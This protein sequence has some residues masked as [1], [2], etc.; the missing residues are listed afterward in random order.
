[1]SESDLS[2]SSTQKHWRD[3]LPSTVP[4][5]CIYLFFKPCIYFIVYSKICAVEENAHMEA[6]G[7]TKGF[8]C[9]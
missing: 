4:P 9:L 2:Y 8:L 1:M 7:G 3:S 5:V 6:L